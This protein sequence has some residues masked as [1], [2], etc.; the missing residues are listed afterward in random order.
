MVNN[1][2]YVIGFIVTI[3]V[4]MKLTNPIWMGA[5]FIVAIPFLTLAGWIWVHH[6]SKPMDWYALEN[7]TF[8]SKRQITL[9]EETL[10]VLEEIK[11][12]LK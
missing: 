12:K 2:K 4:L 8:F 6:M 3:Y 9:Q 10:K 7:T 11:G 5:I 1:F